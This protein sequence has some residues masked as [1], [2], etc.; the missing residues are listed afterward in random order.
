MGKAPRPVFAVP[1][2][3]DRWHCW[4]EPPDLQRSR[5]LCHFPGPLQ[6]TGYKKEVPCFPGETAP[7][8]PQPQQC[9]LA[10]GEMNASRFSCEG[11]HLKQEREWCWYPLPRKCVAWILIPCT[12]IIS[13]L[14][15]S[16]RGRYKL[17]HKQKQPVFSA[18]GR[19][20]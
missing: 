9:F 2:G 12:M 1:A 14:H 7:A 5:Q 15:F 4:R 6:A 19:D 3:K 11:H 13:R 18:V 8:S 10:E 16:E 20:R 17:S